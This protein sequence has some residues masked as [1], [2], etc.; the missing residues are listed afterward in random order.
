MRRSKEDS[1]K[2]RELIVHTARA[3]FA[4]RGVSQ[5]TME[6]IAA[7]AG[8]TR[9]AIYGHFKDK[10]DLFNCMREQLQLP[11]IDRIDAEITRHRDDPLSGVA[12][13]LKDVVAAMAGDAATS[14]ALLIMN[15]KCEYVRDLQRDMQRQVSRCRELTQGLEKAYRSAARGKQLREGIRADLAALETCAFLLGVVRLWLLDEQGDLIKARVGKLIDA[16]ID[17]LR[18]G[19]STVTGARKPA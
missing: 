8:L 14:E 11:M 15:F 17:R 19:S 1:L 6:H 4:R 10:S 7:A 13:Y 12:D 2:T 5:T 3:E 18:A 9:G 16:H